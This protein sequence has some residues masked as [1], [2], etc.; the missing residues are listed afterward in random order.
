MKYKFKYQ[1]S[2]FDLWKLSMYGT[3]GSMVGAS[4]IIFTL[5]MILLVGKFWREAN[6]LM[7]MLLIIGISL[8]AV[9][10]PL[11]VYMRAKRQVAAV[12]HD[13]ELGF[14]D[15]GIQVIT[16]NQNLNIKWSAIKGIIKK[17]SMIVILSTN[18]HGFIITN[19]M[20]GTEKENFYKYIV[21]KIKK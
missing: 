13:M 5:A 18:K 3:Y 7:K 10:Q 6:I 20:V 12:P 17:S 4:N 9:I 19:D 14:D 15:K 16:S 1:T 11:A 8:F 21:S 2:A